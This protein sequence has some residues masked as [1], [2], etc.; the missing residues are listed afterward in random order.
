[1]FC[2]QCGKSL[3]DDSRKCKYCGN[4]SLIENGWHADPEMQEL[5][6]ELEISFPSEQEQPTE[7]APVLEEPAP[8]MAESIPTPEEQ[9]QQ[10]EQSE[11]PTP[12][13]PDASVWT[14]P[15]EA[16]PAMKSVQK[17]NKNRF[18]AITAVLAAGVLISVGLLCRD[19]IKK[20]RPFT[21]PVNQEINMETTAVSIHTEISI[22]DDFVLA[23]DT[24]TENITD[25]AT[26][27]TTTT[28]IITTN[29]IEETTWTT[30]P[31]KPAEIRGFVWEEVQEKTNLTKRDLIRITNDV[32]DSEMSE[33]QDYIEK[34]I[35]EKTFESEPATIVDF[36]HFDYNAENADDEQDYTSNY[37]NQ[38]NM[39]NYREQNDTSIIWN[40]VEYSLSYQK[41][42]HTKGHQY[43]LQANQIQPSGFLYVLKNEEEMDCYFV[44][45]YLKENDCFYIG[46]LDDQNY[47]YP[48]QPYSSENIVS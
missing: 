7:P 6:K 42:D 20:N 26:E 45:L 48:L 39:G 47:F 25:T 23:E 5:L 33:I 16:A 38:N 2:N 32:S 10:P 4:K 34:E 1:M 9:S 30:E 46:K 40:G 27:T 44:L 41:N 28:V 24:T 31:E 8:Q 11:Q 13:M 22:I 14:A 36:S 43:Q 35:D 18:V 21:E 37:E 19:I 15:Q 17:S 29:D 12:E 3:Q